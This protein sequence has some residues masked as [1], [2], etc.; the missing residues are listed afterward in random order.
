MKKSFSNLL[1][2]KGLG[3]DIIHVFGDVRLDLEGFGREGAHSR[4]G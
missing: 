3:E 1:L 4:S 2:I